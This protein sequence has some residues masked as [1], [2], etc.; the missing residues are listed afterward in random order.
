MRLAVFALVIIL[1]VVGVG[2]YAFF[3][4][5]PSAGQSSSQRETRP[6]DGAPRPKSPY[7]LFR[8]MALDRD[9]GRIAAVPLD[10]VNGKR[11]ITPLSCD[12]VHAARDGGVCLAA[13]RGV[14]TSYRADAFDGDFKIVKSFPLPGTP[15]R[16]RV[17]P[18]G[19]MAATTVFVSGDS[20][21]SG[22]FSTRTTLI[23]LRQLTHL[24][25]LEEYAVLRNGRPF[26]RVDFNFWGVTFGRDPDRFYAVLSTAGTLNLVEGSV[27]ARSM[28]VL[29]ERVEC[30]SLSPDARRIAFKS[31]VVEGAR[32]VWRL[33]VL[34]LE[35]G[36][37]WAVNETR[38]VDDQA[39]WLD[40]DHVLYALPRAAEGDGSADIWVA[41]A[42]GTG[43]A[44]LFLA[45]AYSPAVVR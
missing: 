27:A 24:G 8:H 10:A 9:Y 45:D 37:E 28:T 5:R 14:F 13:S 12:R 11:Y 7:V 41:R 23:N 26:K 1:A 22:S 33:H 18:D 31:R 20:Y 39:E 6:S 25:D 34:D 15:S 35:T 4:A 32:L 44:R 2:A 38:S 43:S 3:R 16:A 36:R 42:D 19:T 40:A 29:R 17:S 21:A 30:P